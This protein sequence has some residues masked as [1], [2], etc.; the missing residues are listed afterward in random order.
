M[1]YSTGMVSLIPEWNRRFRFANNSKLAKAEIGG[2]GWAVKWKIRQTISLHSP[3][4]PA[5]H[6]LI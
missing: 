5:D 3:F 2:L 4:Y 6:Y 1:L